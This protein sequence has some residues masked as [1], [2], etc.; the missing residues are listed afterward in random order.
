MFI[1]SLFLAVVRALIL[2]ARLI[3]VQPGY[4]RSRFALAAAYQFEERTLSVVLQARV[5]LG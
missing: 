3:H 1:I 2:D 5:Q 4:V